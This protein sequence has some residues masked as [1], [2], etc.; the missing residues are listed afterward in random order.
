MPICRQELLHTFEKLEIQF[1]QALTE[2]KL[3]DEDFESI[4][5]TFQQRLTGRLYEA[6]G[7]LPDN[8]P[9]TE[10]IKGFIS[11]ISKTNEAWDRKIS[12]R[13][14][15]LEFRAGFNDSLLVF[16]YGKVKSCKSSLGNY[17]AWGNTDPK[18]IEKTK[19][20]PSLLPKYFSHDNSGV[21]GGDAP[22]EAEQQREFRVGATEATSTIQGF[23]LSGLTWVDSP[24]LHSVNKENGQLAKEYVDHA[25]LILYTMKSDAPG[26]ASDLAEIKEL[27]RKDKKTL[28]L[29]TGSDDV[30]EEWD[31]ATEQP[32]RT[33]IMK[34]KDRCAKQH[35]HVR[36]ELNKLNLPETRDIRIVS[37]S[38]RYAQLHE[39]DAKAL[40]DSGMGELFSAIGE[41]INAEGIRLKQQVPMTNFRKF[42]EGCM[43]DLKPYRQLIQNL[44]IPISEIQ[45]KIPRA[46]R[47]VIHVAQENM[48]NEIHHQFDALEKNRNNREITQRSIKKMQGQLGEKLQGLIE[49]GLAQV[50]TEVMQD[51][52][53]SVIYTY[54]TSDLVKLPEF[55]IDTAEEEIPVGVR[56]G[57]RKRNSG[58][59]SLIGATVGSLFGPV[60]M[61]IGAA[62]GGAGGAMTGSDA[63][64][65]TRTIEITLGD[66]L[67]AIK[68]SAMTVCIHCLEETIT[69]QAEILLTALVKDAQRL[70]DDLGNE[71]AS[72]EKTLQNLIDKTQMKLSH[73]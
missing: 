24:G 52:R 59:G 21:I 14:K 26:R 42:L 60:G 68:Q 44:E 48:R 45:K 47:Q 8:N 65:E 46:L 72:V 71:I 33:V 7:K 15:G 13:N 73:I 36:N 38:A 3:Q 9:L 2:A 69:T 11:L 10:N 50:F 23:K 55:A 49:D 17:I 40:T 37:F 34:D 66:N 51:F 12:S 1:S 28:L 67:Q 4:R 31:E 57:T 41:L 62:V 32:I 64:K 22:K 63:T 19:V 54:Q 5:T 35:A 61:A 53:N 56:G 16:V 20:P 18:G 25:D 29:L 27:V 70:T 6:Q 58:L 43:D 39:D 30:V